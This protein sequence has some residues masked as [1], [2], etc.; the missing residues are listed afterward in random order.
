VSVQ[1]HHPA[2]DGGT[3]PVKPLPLGV[4]VVG[5][6]LVGVMLVFGVHCQPKLPEQPVM[7][8]VLLPDP[9]VGEKPVTVQ[10]AVKPKPPEPKPEPPKPE[11]PKPEPPKPP[12][13]KPEPPKPD[14]EKLRQQAEAA[15]QKRVEEANRRQQEILLAQQKAEE[16]R[17]AAEEKAKAEADA[18]AA[19]ERSEERRVGKE[20][21][22]LCRSRWSPYH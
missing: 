5:H 4:A 8:A 13:P 16:Q 18:K 21:R 12:E 2:D 22:R 10:E 3:L 11:P 9:I 14:P 6:L 20:C 17:K 1:E 7:Q 15:E 19:R